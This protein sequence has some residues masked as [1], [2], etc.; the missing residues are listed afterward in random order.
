MIGGVADTSLAP[1]LRL[2][3]ALVRAGTCSWTDPT[4]VKDTAWYP[5][6]SM[7]AAER[8]AFYA[9]RFPVVE[10]DSTYYRPPT[11]A[12][13]EGWV[14][15][16]PPGFTMDIKGW[17]LLTGHPTKKETLWEDLRDELDPESAEKRNVYASH[18]PEDALDEAW[19]RFAEA[20]EPL[21]DAGRLGAVLMQYPEWFTPKKANREELAR[22]RER[23]PDLPVSVELRSPRWWTEDERERTLGVLRDAGLTTV[24]VDAPPKSGLPTV[25]AATAPLAIVRFHGR[26]DDNWDRK[27]I[28]A[29]ERFRYL[30]DR[31][32]LRDWVPK[33]EQ[34]AEEAEQV[35]VLMNNCYQDYGVRNAS[36]LRHLLV[37]AGAAELE[38]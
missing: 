20:L 14:E 26:N 25:V 36:D 9:A 2:G 27:G 28:T 8:L 17:S 19:R 1:V 4:L 12:L 35:H 11:Y 24:V 10:A 32:E 29:A 6:K 3:Q 5:K 34:L 38:V 30:Y 16:T 13:A 7:P 23:W 18:L 33:V 15:R 21:R 31:Q 22:I 37:D